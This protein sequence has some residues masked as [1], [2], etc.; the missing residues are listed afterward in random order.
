ELPARHRRPGPA[1]A[2][3]GA[4]AIVAGATYVIGARFGAR[5]ADPP[6]LTQLTF[7]SGTVGG[8]RYSPDGKTVI[9]AAA[10]EGE[11]YTVFS[12]RPGAP[13]SSPLPL[14]PADVLSISPA[15]DMALLVNARHQGIVFSPTGT[16][17]R[18][19]ISGGA[20]RE[21]AEGMN[22]ADWSPDGS[23]LV[24]ISILSASD[25][26]IDWPLGMERLHTPYWLSDPRLSPDGQRLAFIAHI[27]QG[28]DGEIRVMERTGE[29][30]TLSSGWLS[31]QGLAWAPGGRE[32]WFTGTRVGML[33]GVWAVTLD[34]RERLLYR[35]PTRLL[36]DAVA[37]D[38]RALLS[39]I[40]LRSEIRFGSLREKTERSLSWFDY[41]TGLTM[42]ATAKLIAFVESGESN[43]SKYGV[44]VRPTDGGPA[45]R[46]ADGGFGS[47]S[48]DG[49]WVLVGSAA[50]TDANARLIPTGP[51]AARNLSLNPL[52]L[53]TGGAW[54][55]DSRHFAVTGSEGGHAIRTYD[56]DTTAGHLAPMT[57]EGT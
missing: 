12:T 4:L 22:S 10:W 31:V 29:P 48:P 39:A 26:R 42:S 51:G 50:P 20:A 16:L 57:P 17:A 47:I 36:L 3:A 55:P 13:D 24:A 15:G 28:D 18:A 23:D 7:R 25:A 9:Y 2:A 19:S 38:G 37:P 5:P 6:A 14:P 8:A 52:R 41:A 33:R 27:N 11:P 49:K 40:S 1:V 53:L 21:L 56:L 30:R 43:G 44:F 45:F 46:L 35:A 54:F 34:G 32:I